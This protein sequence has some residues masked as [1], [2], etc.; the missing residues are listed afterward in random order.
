MDL[1]D[2]V[3]KLHTLF[4]TSHYPLAR[5]KLQ[6]ELECSRATVC[7]LIARMRDYL[8][9]P[10]VS[11]PGG[12]GYCYAVDQKQAYELPGLWFNASELHALLACQR[13]LVQVQPGLLEPHLA[14]LQARLEN[15]LRSRRAGNRNV[16]N[17]VRLLGQTNRQVDS[18][19]FRWVSDALLRRK[20]LQLTYHSRSR[21]Q[22]THRT[23]S[24]QR[25]I[26]YRDN[27][28][29]DAWDHGKQAL[30]SFALERIQEAKPLKAKARNISDKQLNDYFASAYGI[31][32]GKPK[33][34]AV[35][36]FSA[37]RSRWVAEETWHPAQKGR[38]EKGRYILEAPYGD[39][40]ELVMDILKH[41][42]HVEVL[43]PAALRQ[44]VIGEM[45]RALKRQVK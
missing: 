6:T 29:L 21:N 36:R 34:T 15:I 28:Y 2:R 42:S 7:R 10:I 17:R 38:F 35:L 16:G 14:P 32:A 22:I 12:R 41:G 1:F 11:D 18:A 33:H 24:P 25:L 31:F 13:L 23:V 4:S 37:E 44:E 45:K 43:A 19:I 3:F 9:A 5:S 39:C 20:R 8:G 30:R 27:W 26:H 40:R